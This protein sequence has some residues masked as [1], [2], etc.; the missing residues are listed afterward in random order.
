MKKN[1]D[2]YGDLNGRMY[3]FSSCLLMNSL[4]ESSSPFAMGYI[5]QSN[6]FG[7]SG[8]SSIAWSQG[9]AGGNRCDSFSLNIH[10]CL[11]YSSRT[12]CSKVFFVLSMA[13]WASS[14]AVVVFRSMVYGSSFSWT[15]FSHSSLA[16]VTAACISSG[17]ML[18]IITGW[19]AL[20]SVASFQ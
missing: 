7:A 15:S 18:D 10:T 4:S 3:P 20:S 14:D 6:A 11:Q 17:L 2:A 13:F 9:L 12:I 5:L 1:G 19:H 16:I 8:K